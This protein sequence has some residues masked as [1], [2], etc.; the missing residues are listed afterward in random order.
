MYNSK[1]GSA[2][3]L[4]TKGQPMLKHTANY[5]RRLNA[6]AYGIWLCFCTNSVLHQAPGMVQRQ[7]RLRK[8]KHGLT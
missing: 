2:Y 3:D 1:R 5:C 8:S 7:L 4:K 6:A